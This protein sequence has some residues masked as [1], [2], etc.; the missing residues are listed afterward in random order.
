ME[1]IKKLKINGKDYSISGD[2]AFIRYSANADGTDFTETWSEG[3]K[4]IGFA[5]GQEAPTDKS[6]YTWAVVLAGEK[7]ATGA[8]VVSTELTGTTADGGNIYTQTF[9]DGTTATFIAPKG[10]NGKDGYNPKRGIDYW[11]PTDK[12][13]IVDDVLEALPEW[14]G[15]SY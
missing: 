7:G 6:E 14:T 5:T 13:E 4:Y 2:N 3:Q 9:D 8:K 10:D 15:G 11:T 1:Q 12:Q